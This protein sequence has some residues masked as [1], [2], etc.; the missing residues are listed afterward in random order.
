MQFSA[1]EFCA[2]ITTAV[3]G[4]L[5]EI[6]SRLDQPLCFP[7]TMR[8]VNHY[9]QHRLVL[10]GDA[11]HTLHP[12]AGQGVNLGL[13]YTIAL[14]DCIA[15][16][17]TKGRDIGRHANLRPYERA[18][19]GEN[20]TMI[21]AMQA[22]KSLFANQLPWVSSLRNTGLTLTDSMPMLKK[23]FMAVATLRGNVL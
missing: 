15:R 4:R 22:L 16:T 2:A 13:Q 19:K 1:T 21:W 17:T 9:T 8:H 23:R 14:A 11:A 10:V 18:R 5:G 3:K 7:L 20:Q 6:Q 12:L